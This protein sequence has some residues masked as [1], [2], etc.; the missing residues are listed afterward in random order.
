MCGEELH[1]LTPAAKDARVTAFESDNRGVL[2]H[3]LCQVAVNPLLP[4]FH[5]VATARTDSHKD[6]LR[7]AVVQHVF[8]DERI[9]KNDLS[10]GQDIDC[11][12]GEEIRR[13]RPCTHE[14][15]FAAARHSPLPTPYGSMLVMVT[16]VVI[17]M[18]MR[19]RVILTDAPDMMVVTVLR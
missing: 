12:N 8:I 14:I 11:P 3:R 17:I 16:V 4:S 13:S 18:V 19:P 15:D 2:R 1:L 6:T 10:S 5:P 7:R 9:V